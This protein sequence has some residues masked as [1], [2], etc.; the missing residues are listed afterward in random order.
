MMSQSRKWEPY[1]FT[2]AGKSHHGKSHHGYTHVKKQ[3]KVHTLMVT[4]AL[5]RAGMH[6]RLLCTAGEQIGAERI[7]LRCVKL[8]LHTESM[9]CPLQ[10]NYTTHNRHVQSCDVNMKLTFS[11]AWSRLGLDLPGQPK[12][13]QIIEGT[14]LKRLQRGPLLYVSQIRSSRRVLL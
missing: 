3:E 1:L 6:F 2:V 8:Q 5:C 12:N 13:D 4:L 10:P 11:H 7:S 9:T 14:P